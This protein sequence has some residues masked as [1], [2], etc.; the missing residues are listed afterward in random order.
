MAQF[1]SPESFAT[2]SKSRELLAPFLTGRGF[3]VLADNRSKTGTAVSQ[4]VI[5]TTAEGESMRA[6][7][8]FC[9]HRPTTPALQLTYAAA[10]LVAKAKAGQEAERVDAYATKAAREGITHLLLV[11]IAAEGIVLAAK[12]PILLVQQIWIQQRAVSAAIISS[13]A[14]GPTKKNHAENGHSPTIHLLETRASKMA[15]VLWQT[16][17]VVDLM[18]LPVTAPL[19]IGVPLRSRADVGTDGGKK[20]IGTQN[21]TARD[22]RV[23]AGVLLRSNF[24]CER[25]GCVSAQPF[26]GFLDVHHIL[27]AD[28]SDRIWTCVALC[29]NCHREAHLSPNARILNAALLIYAMET[30]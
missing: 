13:G 10:Q 27:G 28:V 26:P 18:R 9:W 30:Q 29:P 3:N 22:P 23:R 16:P 24:M 14:L 12:V 7:V 8:K 6:R 5:A 2:E 17:G 1:R 15:D 4:T 11:Q 19:S 25:Q 21:Y 20:Y